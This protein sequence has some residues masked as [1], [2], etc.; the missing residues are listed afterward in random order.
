MSVATL[1]RPTTV[2]VDDFSDSLLAAV[3]LNPGREARRY[4]RTLGFDQAE[5][6][7]TL[8]WLA[9]NG[10]VLEGHKHG[11]AVYFPAN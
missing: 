1:T 10:Y 3:A 9:L 7:R 11:R 4:A 2:A 5:A 6:G 8:R